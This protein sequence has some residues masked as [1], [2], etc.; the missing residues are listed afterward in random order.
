MAWLFNLFYLLL[1]AVASPWL[2]IPS[3][4]TGKYRSGLGERF[5]GLVP[6]RDSQR[7]CVWLHAVSLG[8]V[9]LLQTL[10]E[11]VERDYP[12]WDVVI[13]STTATGYATAKKKY[14]P[15]QVFYAPFDFNW[16]VGNV[17]RRI[18][19]DVLLLA[20]LEVWPN[21]LR[22]AKAQGT[23]VA[24]IN[25]RLGERSFQGYRRLSWLLQSTFAR[26]DVVAAQT[27]Q[28]AERFLALGCPAERV[29]VTGS[30]KFDG[31]QFDRNN[32]AT[33][34][35]AKLAGIDAAAD[36]VFLAGST[37]APEESLALDVFERF[38]SEFP[39]LKLILVPRHP[40][41]FAEVAQLLD[42][43][44]IAWRRR[45][46]L[47]D[48]P[49]NSATMPR[50]LLVDAVGELAAWWGQAKIA[51]VG[52]SLGSRGGQNMIEPAAYGAA[53]S[54]GPNTW[55]FRDVVSLL[56]A[57]DAA[58]VVHDAAGLSQFVQRCLSEPDY[59]ERLGHRAALL[60]REQQGA[61]QQ[62]M[63]LLEPLLRGKEPAALRVD[64]RQR[65]ASARHFQPAAS[66]T[67]GRRRPSA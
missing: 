14:S 13:S 12:D 60:V 65:V 1:L 22:A 42:R 29:G 27:E 64:L 7:K 10:L 61:T 28:Y 53:V 59:A 23:K 39:Q 56:L 2:V 46:E 25:G 47:D 52:G 48:I 32:A 57:N 55:N 67:A 43:R 63:K 49:A 6:P 17:L 16:A 19:P 44:G 58:A 5:F 21:L 20:E 66:S 9:N 45:S 3:L 36:V 15:R 18:R 50:V 26:I 11:H 35:L 33:R 62:T 38:A 34:R 41:R 40:E 54:F 37:Q 24:V 51:F 4:R 30:L 8:E 31:A